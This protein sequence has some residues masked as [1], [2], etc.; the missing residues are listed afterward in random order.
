MSCLCCEVV[1][2]CVRMDGTNAG[3]FTLGTNIGV[4]LLN[5]AFAV[6]E[7]VEAPGWGT[8]GLVP[9]LIG[10][11]SL[12]RSINCHSWSISCIILWSRGLLCHVDG[13]LVSPSGEILAGFVSL[14]A[15]EEPFLAPGKAPSL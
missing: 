11:S 8:R 12:Q 3:A 10:M 7:L 4:M 9:A 13:F 5:D 15:V 2:Y 1:F 6:S 14:R